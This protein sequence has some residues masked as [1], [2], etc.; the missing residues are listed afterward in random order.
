MNPNEID[1]ERLTG[2]QRAFSLLPHMRIERGTKDDWQALHELHYKAEG[3]PMAP[4]IWRCVLEVDGETQL[5]GVCILSLPKL[6]LAPRHLMF[7]K[8]KPDG[9]ETHI[10][11]VHRGKWVNA[12]FTVNSRT[13]VDTLFR[14]VG[15]SYRLLNL[16]ARLEGKRFTE[17]QSSMSK[18]NPFA[19]RAGFAFCKPQDP[20]HYHKAIVLM[21]SLFESHYSDQESILQELGAMS[22][23]ERQRAG[24]ALRDF[25]YRNSALEKTGQNLNRGRGRVDSMSEREVLGNLAQLAFSSPM[26]GVYENP[27]VGRKLPS[28]LPLS[29]FDLQKP[30]E[31][32]RL[33]LL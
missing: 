22:P 16:A 8:L 5:V 18:F 21:R 2:S 13:V 12:N 10:T 27:D 7:P 9:R 26:Y 25:Y 31:P 1:I 15:V 20:K 19:I 23:S 30:N 28:S 11:N 33:D 32:L 29:A 24:E 6:L 3:T 14:S 4:R 17:I